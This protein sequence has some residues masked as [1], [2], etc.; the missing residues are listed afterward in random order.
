MTDSAG[1]ENKIEKTNLEK[2]LGVIVG[3]NLKGIEHKDRMAGKAKRTL[4]MIKR[5]FESR[6]P[7]RWKDLY[8]SLVRAHLEYAV[9]T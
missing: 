7:W 2:D 3:S 8:V 1:H 4:G 5:T 6:K 9:Q